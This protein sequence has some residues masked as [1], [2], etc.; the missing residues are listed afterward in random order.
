MFEKLTTAEEIYSFKLGA[1]LT[2]ERTTLEM[3]GDLENHAQ[4]DDL[5]RL[6]REHA[7]ETQQHIANIERAFQMLGE[8]VD[9]SPCPAIE[10]LEKE[11]QATIKKTDDRVVDAVLLASANETEHHE[12]AVYETLITNAEARGAT[13]VAELLRQ[14]LAQEQAALEKVRAFAKRIAR[15]GV[16]VG[17]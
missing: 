4:R 8:D 17:A 11:G 2:M 5:K 16:A 9:D 12:I 14:N 1:A 6:F 13:D 7:G 10:G 15:D 3:L